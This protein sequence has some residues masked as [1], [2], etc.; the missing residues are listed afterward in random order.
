MV[1]AIEELLV[2]KGQSTQTR[3]FVN[4]DLD[5]LGLIIFLEVNFF[6]LE[7]DKVVYFI[8]FLLKTSEAD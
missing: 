4:I 2:A 8:K 1:G 3:D 5:K 6:S 7:K